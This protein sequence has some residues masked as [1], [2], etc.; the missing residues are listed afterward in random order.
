MTYSTIMTILGETSPL[1]IT[2][3]NLFLTSGG[4]QYDQVYRRI[5][6]ALS[7]HTMEPPQLGLYRV[8]I[9]SEARRHLDELK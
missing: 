2:T 5:K 3:R 6:K 9:S 1:Q 8:L 4:Y 7:T